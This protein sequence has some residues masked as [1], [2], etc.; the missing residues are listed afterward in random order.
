MAVGGGIVFCGAV[1]A[2]SLV[3]FLLVVVS[4]LQVPSCKV[5][6]LVV[7]LAV[8]AIFRGICLV[9]AR[10]RVVAFGVVLMRV[11]GLALALAR[12]RTRARARA[13]GRIL[14]SALVV[15]GVVGVVIGVVGVASVC[16]CVIV[17]ARVI[18]RINVFIVAH[19]L[20]FVR[21]IVCVLAVVAVVVRVAVSASVRMIARG[22][23]HVLVGAVVLLFPLLVVW[24]VFLVLA[25]FSLLP[26]VVSWFL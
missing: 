22:L 18:F 11:R 7:L 6:L 9:R 23:R 8:V 21:A 19:G 16:M 24:V 12:V 4:L 14:V 5:V 13:F 26:M 20:V 1:I 25:A 17:L 10:D 2:V 15:A 3:R